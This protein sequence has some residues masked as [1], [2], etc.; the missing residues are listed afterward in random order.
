M[1]TCTNCG[2]KLLRGATSCPHCGV[3]AGEEADGRPVPKRS[4]KWFWISLAVVVVIAAASVLLL[5]KPELIERQRPAATIESPPTRVVGDRPGGARRAS[6]AK[7]NEAEATRLLRHH[8]VASGAVTNDCLVAMSN[9]FAGNAYRFTAYN[10]CDGTR[11]G[12]WEVNGTT[13]EVTRASPPTR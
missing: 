6:G 5:R 9:G 1:A 2:G 12:R 7:I 13:S 8:L 4:L 11:L 3:F 10:R